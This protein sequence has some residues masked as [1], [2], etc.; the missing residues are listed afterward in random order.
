MAFRHPTSA[1]GD[2]PAP[3]YY[4]ESFAGHTGASTRYFFAGEA[5][6]DDVLR[7]CLVHSE[8]HG[9]EAFYRAKKAEQD[10]KDKLRRKKTDPPRYD[11]IAVAGARRTRR[12]R[13]CAT[14]GP[15]RSGSTSRRTSCTSTTGR[16][17][18][19][20]GPRL[21]FRHRTAETCV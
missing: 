21:R 16:G 17:A 10:K 15:T 9:A 4:D 7:A 19:R 3:R 12:R 5:C 6:G 2:A 8:A 11:W 20:R 14:R 1:W 18:S 13:W